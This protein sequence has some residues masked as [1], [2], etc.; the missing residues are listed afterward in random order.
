[1]TIGIA[2]PGKI[3]SDRAV[4]LGDVF[5]LTKKIIRFTLPDGR[6]KTPAL[7]MTAG[8]SA[9]TWRF[10]CALR[11]GN[12]FPEPSETN[13]NADVNFEAAL[14]TRRGVTYYDKN[15]APYEV[16]WVA[17][18]TGGDFARALV[19]AGQTPEEAVRTTCQHIAGCSL[20]GFEPEIEVI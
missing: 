2:V 8:D 10:E 12:M 17:I 18:G 7:L 3:V 6:K 20:M 11:A 4:N 15:F 16:D 19:I 13:A 14:V 9:L 1:M 5:H